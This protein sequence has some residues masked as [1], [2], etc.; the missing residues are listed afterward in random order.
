MP[1]IASVRAPPP[2]F[3]AL[4]CSGGCRIRAWH[5]QAP[6]MLEWRQE[7]GRAEEWDWSMYSPCFPRG[8]SLRRWPQATAPGSQPA[9]DHSNRSLRLR[10]AYL[11]HAVDPLVL[12]ASLRFPDS[13]TIASQMCPLLE[14]LQ[15][16]SVCSYWA[17]KALGCCSREGRLLYCTR[18]ML[19]LLPLSWSSTRNVHSLPRGTDMT[20]LPLPG[21]G[22]VNKCGIQSEYWNSGRPG[23]SH[24]IT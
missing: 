7:K 5:Q 21:K 8:S 2:S 24:R 17:S 6:L 15:T 11:A 14:S 18:Q 9:T 23:F 13:L 16:L 20:E 10:Q 1:W 4:L 22:Q 19:E 3:S 12:H